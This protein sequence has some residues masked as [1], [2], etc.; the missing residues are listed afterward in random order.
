[1]TPDRRLLIEI[2]HSFQGCD[3]P[4]YY[5]QDGD[6]TYDQLFIA[7]A[8][9]ATAIARRDPVAREPVLIYGHKDRRFVVAYWACI[10]LGRA[11]V[12][13]ESISVS[14]SIAEVAALTGA[15][16]L[17]VAQDTPP[18]PVGHALDIV[19]VM[20]RLTP[21]EALPAATEIG[22]DAVAYVLFSS[23][24]TGRPKG[25]QVSY[26]NVADFVGWMQRLAPDLAPIRCV[27]GNVRYCFD[28]SLF[29]L[30]LAW[31]T[32]APVSAVCHDDIWNLGRYVERFAAHGVTTWVSTPALA[33]QF[34]KRRDFDAAH[35]PR[36]AT[37]LFCG[38]T[39]PKSLVRELF[40]RFPGVRVINTYGPTE[41]TVAVTSVEITCDHLEAAAS[42]PI[43]R[44]RTRTCLRLQPDTLGS[45]VGE[46]II[47][48]ASVGPGYLGA[49]DRQV[50][51]FVGVSSYRTGD[52][53]YI[54]T[55]GDWYFAGRRD[56]EVKLTGHRVDLNAVEN[57]IRRQP[58]VMDVV[59][60]VDEGLVALVVGPR[61][62]GE[63]A[64]AA[65]GIAADLP[66]YCVPRRWHACTEFR[67]NAHGKLDR[68]ALRN[69]LPSDAVRYTNFATPIGTPA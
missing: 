7:A 15:R 38:E 19:P 32:R 62:E 45:D 35:L 69:G 23:G 65:A 11:C 1:M 67:L 5:H 12:P 20:L 50:A 66:W 39:L 58:G 44:P 63:L 8:H 60:F 25:I 33:T 68:V 40:N 52:W 6:L 37:M 28:V 56:R 31:V 51:H 2:F 48:G 43:G 14:A 42:L 17:L 54:G 41:C 30:W 16:L 55:D 10:L 47:S 59:A 46:I 53:G 9:L 18:P 36:L 64:A 26:A 27:T 29:E 22:D 61:T 3:G 49:P 13:V 21:F 24:T 4:A 57:A 34:I